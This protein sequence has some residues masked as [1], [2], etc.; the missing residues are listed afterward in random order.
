MP[1][2]IITRTVFGLP[3]HQ[4]FGPLDTERNL[5]IVIMSIEEYETIRLIDELG[6]NQAECAMEMGIGRTTAQ[7]IYNNARKKIATCIIHGKALQFE[8]G[9]YLITGQGHGQGRGRGS[10]RHGQGMGRNRLR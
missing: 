10:G 3:K 4:R 1:R 8:G 2:P 5:D 9:D 6:H 7:R